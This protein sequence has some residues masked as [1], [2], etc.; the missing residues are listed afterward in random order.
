MSNGGVAPLIV[1]LVI[2]RRWAGSFTLR[3]L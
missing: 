2:V 3:L 1:N